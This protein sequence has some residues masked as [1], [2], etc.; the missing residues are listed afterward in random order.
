MASSGKAPSPRKIQKLNLANGL[1]L[2]LPVP[3]RTL[4]NKEKFFM[5]VKQKSH[6]KQWICTCLKKK[7]YEE[8][9]SSQLPH[10]QTIFLW[11]QRE[12]AYFPE[13]ILNG[14]EKAPCIAH[15]PCQ[16]ILCEKVKFAKLL[17]RYYGDSAW[18]ITPRTLWCHWNETSKSWTIPSDL[19]SVIESYP[20]NRV[21]ITKSSFGSLGSGIRLYRGNT[22]ESFRKFISDQYQPDRWPESLA[23]KGWVNTANLDIKCLI[24]QQYVDRPLL[25]NESFKFDL[26]VYALIATTNPCVLLYHIGKMRVCGV[27]YTDLSRANDDDAKVNWFQE[28]LSVNDTPYGYALRFVLCFISSESQK[29]SVTFL[30]KCSVSI[31]DGSFIRFF[32]GFHCKSGDDGG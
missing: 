12:Y 23:R 20:P 4:S 31:F 9:L 1:V 28:I 5:N 25:F 10:D 26:R 22:A 27:K 17:H 2:P 3:R 6:G 24:V 21:W 19:E 14:N 8:I 11:C 7:G 18:K 30:R 32:G 16:G 15:I 29:H 13:D